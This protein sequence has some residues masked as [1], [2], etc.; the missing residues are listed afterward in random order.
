MW[1]KKPHVWVRRGTTSIGDP[2]IE[3][4]RCYIRRGW[5]GESSPC[6]SVLKSASE[7]RS[8]W[9]AKSRQRY[10]RKRK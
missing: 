1:T 2:L 3:C 5:P 6:E 8:E 10:E 7:Y 9:R 4:E